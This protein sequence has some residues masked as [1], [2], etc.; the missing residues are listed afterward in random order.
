MGPTW[1]PQDPGGPHAGPMNF[2]IWVMHTQFYPFW[3]SGCDILGELTSYERP[4]HQWWININPTD[5]VNIESTSIRGSMLSSQY[6]GFWCLG[7]LTG[8]QQSFDQTRITDYS[9]SSLTTNYTFQHHLS[10]KKQNIF[11]SFSNEQWCPAISLTKFSDYSPNFPWPFSG[12]PWPQDILQMLFYSI[13]TD[14]FTLR[15][16]KFVRRK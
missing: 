4:S 5:W 15:Q 14:S 1:W 3:C 8:H 16:V 10:D 12:F 9:L 6:H 11:S 2:A 13:Y 7:S